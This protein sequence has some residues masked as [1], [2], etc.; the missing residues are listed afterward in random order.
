MIDKGQSWRVLRRKSETS[1]NRYQYFLQTLCRLYAYVQVYS[2][3]LV[4]GAGECL[5]TAVSQV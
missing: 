5:C 1:Q 2:S 3:C 4:P